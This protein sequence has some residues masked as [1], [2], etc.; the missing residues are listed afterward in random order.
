MNGCE[1][2]HDEECPC[3]DASLTTNIQCKCYLYEPFDPWFNFLKAIANVEESGITSFERQ[4]M[5][6]HTALAGS[7]QDPLR[8]QVLHALRDMT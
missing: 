5:F 4:T 6:V 2:E 3:F 8:D 1:I 7:R